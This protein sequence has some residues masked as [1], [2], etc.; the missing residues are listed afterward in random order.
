MIYDLCVI[1]SGPAGQNAAISA[2]KENLKVLVIEKSYIGGVCQNTGTIPS[3]TLRDTAFFMSDF[4]GRTKHGISSS[5]TTNIDLEKVKSRLISIVNN[6]QEFIHRNLEKNNIEIAKGT[7]EFIDKNTIV[8]TDKEDRK[9]TIEAKNILIATGTSPYHPDNITFDNKYIFDSN[10]ILSLNFNA[11]RMIIVGAGVIGC[12]YACIFAKLG[13]KVT[14]IEER[15]RL[16]PFLDEE[17][18][19]SLE[20]SMRDSGIII[21]MGEKIIDAEITEKNVVKATFESNKTIVSDVLLYTVGRYGNIGKLKLENIN[22]KTNDRGHIKVNECMQTE[23]EGIYAVGDIIGT[24]SLASTSAMQGRIA[25]SKMFKDSYKPMDLNKITYG[26]YTI[27][28]ISMV[29]ETE[30]SLSNKKIPYEV[31]IGHFRE[32]GRGQI[33]GDQHGIL[34][35]LFHR[36][37]LTLLGVHAIGDLVTEIIHIGQAILKHEGTI[38]YF[39]DS[40]FNYPTLSEVY[41]IAAQNGLNRLNNI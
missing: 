7:A 19:N 24:P 1:G 21:K 16:L 36:E 37:N 27:P 14:L 40:V 4:K 6:G 41:K 32:T 29:G 15:D 38:D 22:L 26:I 25:A 39:I 31:G 3:K 34:K 35:L 33:I 20:F 28:E 9:E 23:I 13:I 18:S 30:A 5:S 10:S 8:I 11:K 17:I 2:A 12:E